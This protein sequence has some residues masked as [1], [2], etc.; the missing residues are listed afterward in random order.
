MI[1][2]FVR[3]F[4]LPPAMIP[5]IDFVVQGREMELVVGLG[6]QTLTLDQV[7]EMLQ[8]PRDEA[9]A[10]LTQAYYRHVIKRK[11]EDGITTYSAETF[12][13]RLDPLSMYEAWGDVP[14]DAREAVSEWQLQEFIN[15]W[16]P[17]AE[18]MRKDP[19]AFSRIPNRDV[20]LLDEALEMVEAATD[21]VVVPCDCRAIVMACNRPLE[22]CIRLDEGARSALEQGHGRRLTKDEMKALVIELDRAGLMHTGLRN[23]KERGEVYH[24]CNCC[25]CDC[26]PIRAGV[27]LGMSQQWPRAHHVADRDLSKCHM[28]GKCAQRCHF[29]AFYRDG[30]K[31][32]VKGKKAKHVAFD[33][34]KCWGCGLCA[35]TCPEEAITMQPLRAVAAQP[36]DIPVAAMTVAECMQ[37]MANAFVEE[38]M[39]A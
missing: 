14:A 31:V 36:D 30:T 38:E 13:R 5:H 8:M 35:T 10:F 39:H 24:L 23:W 25:A 34:S 22:S 20:L 3:I 33:A 29:G 17:V 7:A 11:T 4:E 19:D 21:H 2:D 32:L 27:K 12:Y 18:E 9:E 26:Y 16:L 1:D 28:C 6:K 37:P 15:L